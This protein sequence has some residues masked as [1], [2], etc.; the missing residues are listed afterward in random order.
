MSK[1][2]R[3]G[4]ANLVS[5]G[6]LGGLLLKPSATVSPA[7]QGRVVVAIQALDDN[8]SVTLTA[9]TGYPAM[10]GE[11]LGAGSTVFGR[12]KLPAGPTVAGRIIA[13]FESE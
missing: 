13:Y 5:F 6:Q 3:Q 4:D 7:D 1:L 12:W 8:S 10:S 9:E 11:A 2:I